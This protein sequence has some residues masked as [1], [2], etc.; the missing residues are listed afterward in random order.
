[1][2][3]GNGIQEIKGVGRGG[4]RGWDKG[5][6]GKGKEGGKKREE[7]LPVFSNSPSLIFLEVSLGMVREGR[8]QVGERRGEGRGEE[9]GD[10]EGNLDRPCTTVFHFKL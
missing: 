2:G 6:E 4:G 9:A 10:G 5:E 8:G 7:Y 3:K 1:L